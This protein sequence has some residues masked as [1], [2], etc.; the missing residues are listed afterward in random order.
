MNNVLKERTFP[1]GQSIQIVQ[2]DITTEEEEELVLDLNIWVSEQGL[3]EGDFAYEVL[4]PE[5]EKPIAFLDLAWPNGL[6]EGYSEPYEITIDGI[7]YIEQQLKEPESRLNGLIDDSGPNEDSDRLEENAS[8]QEPDEWKP[9]KIDREASEYVDAITATEQALKAIEGDNGYAANEPQ[10]RD[11]I[12]WSIRQGL[13][14]LKE[15][16]PSRAQIRSLLSSSLKFIATKFAS[17]VIGE[18]A[19]VALT[20]IKVW[21][22][23]L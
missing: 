2:G 21:L 8:E 7:R 4:D 15:R 19:K 12:V 18:A 14:A 9:L 10:E 20:A 23:T 17:T 1:T 16:V 13:E 11:Q 6:Q 3:P 5:T 22:S